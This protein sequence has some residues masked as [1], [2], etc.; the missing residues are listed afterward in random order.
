MSDIRTAANNRHSTESGGKRAERPRAL[1][2]VTAAALTVSLVLGGF[3]LLTGR[4][5]STPSDYLDHPANPFTDEDSKAQVVEPTKQIVLLTGLRT[6]SAGYSLMSCKDQHDPPY[7]GAVYLT[8][9]LP[10][11][12]RAD[13]YFKTIGSTLG[14]HGWTEGI[15]DNNHV[16]SKTFSKNPVTVI[17]YRD[18]DTPSLGILR[19]YGE[20]RNVNHHRT[21]TTAWTDITDQFKAP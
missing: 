4:L 12:V 7:Q 15:P 18:T 3:F 17:I 16:F 2:F 19:L 8:F 1:R 10:T 6:A 20:C 14:S 9:T 5:H 11:E 13:T 21:D